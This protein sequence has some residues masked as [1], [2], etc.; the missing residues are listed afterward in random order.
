M[1]YPLHQSRARNAEKVRSNGSGAL[2]RELTDG[3]MSVPN[4]GLVEWCEYVLLG[5]RQGLSRVQSLGDA[6][7]VL[8][9]LVIPVIEGCSDQPSCPRTRPRPSGQRRLVVS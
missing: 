4:Q 8:K 2:L 7:S 1:L 6:S 3:H 9:R 5:P